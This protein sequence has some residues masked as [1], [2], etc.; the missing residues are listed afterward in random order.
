M[1]AHQFSGNRQTEPISFRR[2]FILRDAKEGLEDRANGFF[3]N[4][5]A[6]ILHLQT[7]PRFCDS[8]IYGK[9]NLH[10]A[11]R[12][13]VFHRVADDIFKGASQ[14]VHVGI[15]DGCRR[16][17]VEAHGPALSPGL[18]VPVCGYF[19]DEQ[20]DLARAMFGDDRL[21]FSVDYPF[22]ETIEAV[23]WFKQLDLPPAVREKMAYGTAEQLR[24][25]P[26]PVT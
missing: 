26:A 21:V 19:F 11:G 10:R 7:G 14:C 3:R 5:G 12:S 15:F 23:D 25:R 16:F 4:A 18:K 17:G 6:V 1:R 22:E 2:L 8:S 20:F 9:R 24:R 13:R